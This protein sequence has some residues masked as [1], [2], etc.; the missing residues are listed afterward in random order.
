MKLS[1]IGGEKKNC[2]NGVAENWR[3][4]KRIVELLKL[5][6]KRRAKKLIG[7]IVAI[8]EN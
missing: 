8:A 1:K 3:E 7:I 2:G 5:Q 6:G 4:K